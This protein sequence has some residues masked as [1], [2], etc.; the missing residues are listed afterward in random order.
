MREAVLV[1]APF[2]LRTLEIAGAPVAVLA[3]VMQSAYAF[4]T[5]ADTGAG[6]FSINA[7]GTLV[8][9]RGGT[10]PSVS[11]PI[12]RV[13][14]AG[15][16]TT[17][18]APRPFA[19][20]RVSPDGMQL[21]ASTSGR[22]RDIWLHSFSRGTLTRRPASGRNLVPIWARDGQWIA[23]AS[24]TS[25]PDSLHRI[26]ADG[27]GPPELVLARR[28]NL[29]PGG[30]VPGDREILYYELTT[31]AASTPLVWRAD[32]GGNATSLDIPGGPAGTGGVDVSPDG[33]WL[34]YHSAESGQVQ[35]YVQAYP[36]PGPR[37]Q[38]SVDGGIS[39]VWRA[40]GRE[41]FYVRSAPAP[42]TER[43]QMLAV[44]VDG[45]RNGLRIGPPSVLFEGAYRMNRPARSYDV[46][47][48]GA[49]FY[50][51]QSSPQPVETIT[52]L[53]VVQNWLTEL[54]RLAPR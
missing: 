16:T 33:R 54:A 3:D 15:H 35:V 8:Y 5:L 28:A 53:R 52:T 26:R 11:W 9:V 23:Y 51:I 48:D 14:R 25:G 12:V 29:V 17:V 40:D 50:L 2:D 34:A 21:A 38:V 27:S 37:Y 6:Q 41:L 42:A 19:T 44:S 18:L 31:G 36:G 43:V 47:P 7:A 32:L 4:G 10:A 20:L 49:Y 22:D 1:A 45:A 46:S 24:A 13:D 30:F 39:P